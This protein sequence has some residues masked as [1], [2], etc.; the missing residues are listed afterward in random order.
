[1]TKNTR[2][3]DWV[4]DESAKQSPKAPWARDINPSWKTHLAVKPPAL[5]VADLKSA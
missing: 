4:L 3:M 2:W 1:M 5:K